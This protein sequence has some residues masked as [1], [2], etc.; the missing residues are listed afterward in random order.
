MDAC[1]VSVARKPLLAAALLG[2]LSSLTWA[3]PVYEQVGTAGPSVGSVWTTHFAAGE[4]GW[5]TYDDFSLAAAADIGRV[6]WRGIYLDSNLDNAAPSTVG[7]TVEIWS[8]AGGAPGALLFSESVA[9]ASVTRTAVSGTWTFGSE[10]DLYDFDLDLSGAFSAAAGTTY[11]FSVQSTAPSFYPLFG[12]SMAGANGSTYQESLTGT[13]SISSTFVRGG[14]R[15]FALYAD[16]NGVPEPHSL[17]L[18][19]AALAGGALA[20]RGGRRIG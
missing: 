14:D 6:T 8:S 9:A 4:G 16:A 12:W 20:T 7:W 15:A 3:S 10:V 11:W 17:A 5:Q 18:V 1:L 13:G 2:C 19:L